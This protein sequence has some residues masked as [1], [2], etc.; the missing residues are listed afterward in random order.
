MVA[1]IKCI[2]SLILLCFFLGWPLSP[3]EYYS[4]SR[5]AAV[6]LAYLHGQKPPVLHLNLRPC[7]ILIDPNGRA[8]ISDFGFSKIRC[9]Y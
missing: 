5:D 4:I 1:A 2:L 8:K 9:G 3:V 6:G 7:N